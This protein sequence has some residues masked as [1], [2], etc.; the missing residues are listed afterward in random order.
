M[1]KNL[2]L[3]T[4]QCKLETCLCNKLTDKISRQV[5]QALNRLMRVICTAH[6]SVCLGFIAGIS[7][8][9]VVWS[10]L[11]KWSPTGT[12]SNRF[13]ICMQQFVAL[14]YPKAALETHI[15]K[16]IS[17]KYFV[18]NFGKKNHYTYSCCLC[19][20]CMCYVIASLCCV[21][22]NSTPISCRPHTTSGSRKWG[23]ELSG[24]VFSWNWAVLWFWYS[25]YRSVSL[26][27][28]T[29]FTSLSAWQREIQ[30][31]GYCNH[32]LICSC[33]SYIVQNSSV[34][35][36]HSC[37]QKRSACKITRTK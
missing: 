6:W 28:H 21:C 12:W 31:R 2:W 27:P 23:W 30:P 22:K 15:L 13:Q 34:Y 1:C 11:A 36:M 35:I 24:G 20:P 33:L 26:W 18:L 4:F 9:K 32:L 29:T 19:G 37:A 25:V 8:G 7:G 14:T 16:I 17:K 3:L 5:Y 10:Y